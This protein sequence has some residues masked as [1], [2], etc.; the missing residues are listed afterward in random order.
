MKTKSQFR[1]WFDLMWGNHYIQV[2]ILDLL[3]MGLI[4]YQLDEFEE[5]WTI[6]VAYGIPG[7]ACL[8]IIYLGFYKFWQD[9]KDKL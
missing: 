6:G 5:P 7:L 8:V 4:T 3:F 1:K 9:M 2:F